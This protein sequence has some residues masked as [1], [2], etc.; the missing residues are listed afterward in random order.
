MR[1]D[2]TVK[3]WKVGTRSLRGH[4]LD[5]ELDVGAEM[6]GVDESDPMVRVGVGR[7]QGKVTN[8]GWNNVDI[9]RRLGRV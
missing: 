7:E 3:L 5:E 1:L 2:K 9:V 8:T 4:E 6:E